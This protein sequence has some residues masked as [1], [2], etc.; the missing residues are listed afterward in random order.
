MQCPTLNQRLGQGPG[1]SENLI[2]GPTFNGLVK[3]LFPKRI[4]FK[5][6]LSTRGLVMTLLPVRIVFKILLQRK[7]WSRSCFQRE[8][9]LRSYFQW[10]GQGSAS[11]ENLIQGPSLNESHGQGPASK[12]SLMQVLPLK[13]A[14]CK[15]L[16]PKR[17]LFKVLRS[18][19]WSRLCF[20][21]LV[22][23]D[24]IMLKL[25]HTHT[26]YKSCFSEMSRKTYNLLSD[27]L[28]SYCHY[29]DIFIFKFKYS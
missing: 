28:S 13:R 14:L 4:L 29:K 7:A 26:K 6:L 25:I 5:I 12:E 10:P 18:M 22:V 21:S 17:A 1:C 19:V 27:I 2:Q 15:V 23:K 24:I 20:K 3:A 8:P 16:P 11:S 9:Y